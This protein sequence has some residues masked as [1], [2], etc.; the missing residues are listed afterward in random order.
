MTILIKLGWVTTTT[1]RASP[2]FSECRRVDDQRIRELKIWYLEGLQRR[3]RKLILGIF[4]GADVDEKT[5]D[6]W[7]GRFQSLWTYSPHPD[8]GGL[9]HGVIYIHTTGLSDDS[10]SS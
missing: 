7:A 6:L 5:Q 2:K 1:K 10:N 4:C 3:P 9:G 8:E